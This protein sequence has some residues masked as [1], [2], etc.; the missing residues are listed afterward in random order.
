MPWPISTSRMISV[1][2]PSSAMRMKAFGAEVAGRGAR[3]ARPRGQARRDDE[4]AGAGQ[5]RA[6][7][8]RGDSR[9]ERGLF[10]QCRPSQIV[11]ACLMAALMRG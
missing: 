7:I 11:A 4:R 9:L 5:E 1:I 2:L 3:H 10:M 8:E 6:A